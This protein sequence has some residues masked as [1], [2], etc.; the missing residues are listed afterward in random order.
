MAEHQLMFALNIKDMETLNIDKEKV[1]NA[2]KEAGYEQKKVLEQLFDVKTFR[3]N[4]SDRIKTFED[5]LEEL[6]PNHSLVKEYHYLCYVKVSEHILCYSKLCIITA[7]LNEGW[8]PRYIKNERRYYPFF[9]F[10]TDKDIDE[11][12]KEKISC[13]VHIPKHDANVYGG[14]LYHS[15]DSESIS[16]NFNPGLVFK[17]RELAAYAGKQFIKLYADYYLKY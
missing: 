5:A 2:Y 7:A 6:G 1:I 14:L 17:T 3:L 4:I 8:K 11:I 9:I 13:L 12:P 15:G 16:A 10:C